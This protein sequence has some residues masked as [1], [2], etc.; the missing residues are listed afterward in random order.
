M[1]VRDFGK[2]C[3]FFMNC[4]QGFVFPFDQSESVDELNRRI[5]EWM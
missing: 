5:L 1:I 3:W 2:F 4:G